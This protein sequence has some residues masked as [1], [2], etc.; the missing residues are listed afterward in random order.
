M[1]IDNVPFTTTNW[2]NISPQ[3][4]KGESGY[5]VTKTIEQGSI[6]LRFIEYSQDYKANHWCK[7]GHVA[8]I[9]EGE[10]TIE[11]DDGRKFNLTKGMSF[12]VADDG[13]AHRAYSKNGAKIFIVD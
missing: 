11:L 9:M 1:L 13:D 10:F 7:K 6:R 4:F 2:N 12:Q 5:A 3:E 8:L